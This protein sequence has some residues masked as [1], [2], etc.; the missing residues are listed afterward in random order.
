MGR[1]RG[2]S[3]VKNLTQSA[4]RTKVEKVITK[5]DFIDQNGHQVIQF[6]DATGDLLVRENKTDD[7][8]KEIID[9]Q[10][11]LQKT[12]RYP[13]G[14]QLVQKEEI[15]DYKNNHI[16][17][18]YLD[19][20]QNPL[21][22]AEAEKDLPVFQ[23]L[24]LGSRNPIEEKFSYT[25]GED[26]ITQ[27]YKKGVLRKSMEE[28]GF[29]GVNLSKRF[30]ANGKLQEESEV[31]T[32]ITSPWYLDKKRTYDKQGKPL[33]I[34]NPMVSVFS[35]DYENYSEGIW[36]Q[37]YINKENDS[38]IITNESPKELKTPS[39][40][41]F[42]TKTRALKEEKFQVAEDKYPIIARN[43][44]EGPAYTEFYSDGTKKV[45]EYKVLKSSS[46]DGNFTEALYNPNGPARIEFY[47]NG[48]PKEEMFYDINP[49]SFG[50]YPTTINVMRDG[51]PSVKKYSQDGE[52]RLEIWKDELGRDIKIIDYLNP[53]NSFSDGS[54][55]KT[56]EKKPKRGLK[57]FFK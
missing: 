44:L 56:F 45:E 39:Y 11:L 32:G 36:L 14:G 16:E 50:H 53:N 52:L 19:R 28:K 30:F 42:R 54:V 35:L 48:N 51:S 49:T 3:S 20:N 1:G 22:R 27:Y 2:S 15:Y 46:F 5:E 12:F 55:E 38:S 57:K 18:K 7:A 23:I 4:L 34:E 41:D 17:V 43:P 33:Y 10:R 8:V 24:D 6:L 13:E 47:K 31:Y 29:S 9:H 21:V 40:Q 25:S 37:H 26:K